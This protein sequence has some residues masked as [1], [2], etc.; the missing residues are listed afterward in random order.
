[1]LRIAAPKENLPVTGAIVTSSGDLV[2]KVG[3]FVKVRRQGK[4][5]A[6]FPVRSRVFAFS[7]VGLVAY[8]KRDGAVEVDGIRSGEATVTLRGK[9]PIARLAFN[10]DATKLVTASG[11][12]HIVIWALATGRALHEFQSSRAPVRVALS[13]NGDVVATGSANGVIRL[14]SADGKRLE[15]LRGHGNRI[16]DLRFNSD[17]SRLVSASLGSSRNAIMWN[18]RSGATVHVLVGQFGTVTAASFSFDDRWILTAGPISAVLWRADTGRSL[19]YLR[20]HTKEGLTDAEWIPQSYDVLSAGRDGTVRTYR[21][22][23]CVPLDRL[24]Q[25]AKKRLAAAR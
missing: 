6:S 8:V 17:G 24:V 14:W 16:T 12:G 9:E 20:G 7:P 4:V 22:E 10:A 13:P 19:P 2:Y 11:D 3:S 18:V 15:I 5:V 23:V 21:C 25:L 1:M